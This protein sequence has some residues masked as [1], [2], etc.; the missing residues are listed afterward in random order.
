M[1]PAEMQAEIDRLKGVIERNR[2][3]FEDM[4]DAAQ[5]WRQRA[6]RAEAAVAAAAFEKIG[7]KPKSPF[8]DAFDTIFG[9]KR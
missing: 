2:K 6:V 8:D 7:A 1:S 3:A 5:S 9:G 4:R